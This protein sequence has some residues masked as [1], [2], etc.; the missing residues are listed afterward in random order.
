MAESHPG[1]LWLA[2]GAA[3][4]GR[5][6]GH[7]PQGPPPHSLDS[8]P[9]STGHSA[10]RGSF[11]ITNGRARAPTRRLPMLTAPHRGLRRRP[12]RSLRDQ[13]GLRGLKEASGLLST[14]PGKTFLAEVGQGQVDT[15]AGGQLHT[16]MSFHQ[17]GNRVQ[18]RGWLSRPLGRG[19]LPGV[20]RSELT[21]SQNCISLATN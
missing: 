2:G 10:A 14:S 12:R 19:R 18:G 5:V 13:V 17:W 4:Q 8:N 3:E 9:S 11:R 7:S 21:S 16:P 15:V 6:A 20:L 1:T